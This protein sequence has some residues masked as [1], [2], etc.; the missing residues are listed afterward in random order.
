MPILC[1]VVGNDYD[2]SKKV[3]ET[4]NQHNPPEFA[5][6]TA[7]AFLETA[8]FFADLSDDSKCQEAFHKHIIGEYSKILKDIGVVQDK[9]DRLTIEPY[10]WFSHPQVKETIRKLAEAEY[11]A[12]GSD[13]ALAIL[14]AMTSEQRDE[15]IK[16][17]VTENVS[18]G[19]EIIT[20]GGE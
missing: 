20:R 13:R 3:F 2:N 9:L 19:I 16:R 1:F 5:I 14:S 10:D 18:V 12:G 17:L 7:L 15:Y 6:K 4:L 11:N 8:T